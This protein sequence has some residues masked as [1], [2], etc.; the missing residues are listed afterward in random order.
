MLCRCRV[1]VVP[2][3]RWADRWPI[4]ATAPL[5]GMGLPLPWTD[6]RSLEARSNRPDPAAW[7][8]AG[9]GRGRVAAG[10]RTGQVPDRPR[11]PSPNVGSPVPVPRLVD[12]VCG[13]DPPRTAE[14]TL[15]SP[16]LAR[17]R[18][19]LGSGSISRTPGAY[20]LELPAD[21]VDVFRFEH[22]LEEGDLEEALAEWTAGSLGRPGVTGAG[23]RPRGVDRAMAGC[24]RAGSG[25]AG[26]VRPG[27]VRGSIER[28]DHDPPVPR[29]T[30]GTPH[31]RAVPSRTSG[32]RPGVVPGRS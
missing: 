22:L 20:R 32:R 4:D 26:R 14:R 17:I 18:G 23:V 7:G 5:A 2:E 28:T 10:C 6:G 12:A 25:V 1:A 8:S 19:V 31:D 9:A 30:V 27:R 21:S 13:E 15:S 16:Y 24:R 3:P 11:G 29:G